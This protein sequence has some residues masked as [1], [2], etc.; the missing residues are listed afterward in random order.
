M[1]AT[2]SQALDLNTP[3]GD[4]ESNISTSAGDTV[5]KA[6][7]Q[8]LQQTIVSL[9]QKLET[10]KKLRIKAQTDFK[11]VVKQW[12]QVAQELSKQ[13]TDAK[14]FHTVTDDYL[15]QLAE[16]LRYDVR[17]FSEAYFEDLP[18]QSRL[19]SPP[20]PDGR[21]PLDIL[22]ER[23]EQ[24]PACPALVQSFIWRVLKHRVFERY[25]WPANKFVGV[26]L[27][28]VSEFLNPKGSSSL[29]E[30]EGPDYEALRKFHIWRATTSNMVLS[31]DAPVSPQDRWRKFEDQLIRDH[32]DPVTLPFIPTSEY[33]RYFD[34]LSKIIEKALVMD[35]EISRQAAWVRWVFEDPDSPLETV[36]STISIDGEASCVIVAPAMIKRGKSSGEGFEEQ[37]QLL[38]ADTCVVQNLFPLRTYRR[39]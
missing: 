20:P 11:S 8:K 14:L 3:I 17:C 18:P 2:E 16:E 19:Q 24:C 7:L 31:A 10:E 9:E 29:N 4:G 6:A 22:P 39:E 23:Y 1:A 27:H 26:D 37:I 38:Q 32:I 30:T 15:K 33:G 34:L 36:S 5:D 13:H 12:K 21:S 35:R 25:E 28:R